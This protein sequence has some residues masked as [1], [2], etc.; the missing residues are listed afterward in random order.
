MKII[1]L[2]YVNS[3]IVEAEEFTSLVN[4]LGIVETYNYECRQVGFE[5]EWSVYIIEGQNWFQQTNYVHSGVRYDFMRAL[6]EYSYFS[7]KWLSLWQEEE[8]I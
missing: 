5:P 3:R 2:R 1:A 7:E 6:E 4:A 8:G